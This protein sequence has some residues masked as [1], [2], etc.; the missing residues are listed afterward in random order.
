MQSPLLAQQPEVIKLTHLHALLF[1]GSAQQQRDGAP[2]VEGGRKLAGG[3][4]VDRDAP[5]VCLGDVHLH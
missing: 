3:T 4:Q 5:G 2:G 1:Q